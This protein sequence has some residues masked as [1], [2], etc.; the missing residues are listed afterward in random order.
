MKR[1]THFATFALLGLIS[2]QCMSALLNLT[3]TPLFLG[4]N[5]PPNVMLQLDDSG[6]MDWEFMQKGYWEACA[7]DPNITGAYSFLTT[8][9]VYWDGDDGLRSYGNGSFRNF[10]YIFKNANNVYNNQ[11]GN[12]CE[13][14][15]IVNEIEACPE[16]GTNDW[17]AFAH[18][19]N[20]MYYSP[21]TTYSPWL[22]NCTTGTLCA[23][24]SFNAVRSY[25]VSGVS[26]YSDTRSLSGTKYEVWI[27]DKGY[28]G[29]RPLRGLSSNMTVGANGKVD[30]WDSHV[31]IDHQN[32][33]VIRVYS[34]TYAPTALGLNP[35]TVLQTTLNSGACY[36]VLGPQSL[37][38]SIFN[39]TMAYDS[40]DAPGC[41]TV[42]EAQT[43]FSNW[44]QYS[45][46]R[47]L[48]ARGAIAYVLNQYPFFRYS[49]NTINDDVFVQAP[50]AGTTDF[51]SQNNSILNAL[52]TM[53]WQQQGT[54]L[55]VG[56]DRAGRYYFNKLSNKPTPIV[57]ACQQNYTILI[58][59]GFWNDSSSSLS[60]GIGDNDKDGI[61]KTLADVARYYYS[62]DLSSLA[63]VVLPSALDPAT[64]Q[65]MVTF[66]MAYGLTGN[67]VAGQDGWPNPPKAVN[68][69]W[70]NPFNDDLAKVDDMWHAAF[71]SKGTYFG[72][73]DPATSATAF[74]SILSNI[75]LRN[76][77]NTSAAQNSAV[78]NT[79][80]QVYQAT[81]NT[82]SWQGDVL[83]FP[84]SI[85]GVLSSTP[86]WSAG[87]KLTG[88]NCLSPVGTNTALAPNSRVII[89][90]N[91][92]GA[93]NGVAFRWPNNYATYKV[94]GSLPANMANFLSYAPFSA[95][96]SNS[97]EITANQAYGTALVNYLR[98][99]RS[100]EVQYG[101]SYG[102]RNRSSV[103]G[104]IVDST[105]VFIP[106]PF[107]LYPDNLEA[108]AYSAFKTANASR[109]PMIFTGA[110]DGMLHGFN[111]NT[112]QEML[113][114][115]P[116]IRQ[117]YQNLPTLSRTSYT[118]AYFVDGSPVE[119]DV[120]FSSA[121]HTIVGGNLRNGGQG[122]Y[123]I[124][125]T[126]P[127]N[128]SET[129]AN[130]I[131]LWEFTDANDPDLG[132]VQGNPVIAKV[133]T[134]ASQSKWAVIFGN[135]YNNSQADGF[136]STN[137]KAALYILLI[138]QGIGG[139]WVADT[140]FYKIPVGTGSVGTP[141]GLAAPYAIDI[142]ND[143][144][145]DYV[146]AGD[147][148]GNVWKFDLTDANPVNW[149]NNATKLFQAYQTTPGDQPIT[150]PLVVGPHP[151]GLASG[152][153]VYFGTGKYLEPGDDSATGQVTQSFYGIWDKLNGSTVAKTSLLQQTITSEVTPPQSATA[154]RSAS[155]NPIKW[156]TPNQNLGWYI[157]LIVSGSSANYG[158]K[159]VSQPVLRNNNVIF[160][161]LIPAL[162]VCS[163]GG[164]SWLM[165]LNAENGGQPTLS[166][167]DINNDGEFS[168][169]DY[170]NI[171]NNTYVPAAGQKSAV[172][173]TGTPAIMLA[174]DKKSETKVLS[175]SQGIGAVQ[176]N[177]ATGQSG[178]QNWRQL[179]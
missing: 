98:G 39:G 173:M 77:S 29:S 64:W 51:I 28:L 24:A 139:N 94:S 66:T 122:V 26:G 138:E 177:P 8:C 61:S 159:Q 90:R 14:N 117:I 35:T 96:T 154:Y 165:E 114:Y 43:N 89:T 42:A 178:R 82:N 171:G 25:P 84:I 103:L 99:V 100:N 156:T 152:V 169:A 13:S 132:F 176:E 129:N 37:V 128:F 76:S 168:E 45:R 85:N 95:N 53:Q 71:N 142:N 160:T 75:V 101:G 7:Y 33:G 121:W 12:G 80:S 148:Q 23:D 167:F 4:G 91:W 104:D 3:Q 147:L 116:G 81:F 6:S 146:Y 153:M 18:G 44:Y 88:G 63:N 120:Y 69:N 67:L 158:E 10:N 83:A 144:I 92:T 118:H 126:N 54:P 179:Y 102:F 52:M 74:S 57:E 107:R 164:S 137:G 27:D 9:G 60:S 36:N 115:I 157:N 135:G 62:T 30:I 70:G 15:W 86:A 127:A 123:T 72:S 108:S 17:R 87:C 1:T 105:P 124:D 155:N 38:T 151:N 47:S 170:I 65:H 2:P 166:I 34:T 93:N 78:L 112:G 19:L 119:A 56:L 130:Q 97:A 110:N 21:D 59:D 16:S 161:T 113:A 106:P 22:Y 175:G 149:K 46:R 109:T 68:G 48:A 111:A 172:G 58:S 31:T 11:N 145:V 125:V 150:A 55:R 20:Q 174:P 140:N 162:D 5:V 50:S 41:K 133:K 136:A 49:F 163:F 134:S 141:N 32:P 79:N 73:Q 40:T 131:Y 143:Y